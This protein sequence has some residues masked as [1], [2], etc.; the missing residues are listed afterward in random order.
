MTPEE[1]QRAIGFITSGGDS[2]GMNAAVR[3][4]V[5]T[6]LD[7]PAPV[8]A[9][10]EGYAGMCAGDPHFRKMSWDSV[11]GILHQGGTVIGTA[12]SK[13]FYQPEGRRSAVK[14]LVAHGID[15]LIVIGGD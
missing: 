15:R 10:T 8:Y 12:R 4:I 5:R 6:A 7:L 3:A 14:N 9:I 2:P 11:G 13:G 1:P